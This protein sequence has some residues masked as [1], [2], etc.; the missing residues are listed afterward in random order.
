MKKE[1]KSLRDDDFS[2]G[3][4]PEGVFDNDFVFTFSLASENY[5]GSLYGDGPQF[6]KDE[7]GLVIDVVSTPESFYAIGFCKLLLNSGETGWLPSRWLVKVS[8]DAK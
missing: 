8:H 7:I 6:H 3:D 5:Q 1:V 4:L 2:V